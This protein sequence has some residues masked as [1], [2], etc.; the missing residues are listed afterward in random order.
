MD[1]NQARI[2][3]PPSWTRFVP[4]KLKR[5]LM[6]PKGRQVLIYVQLYA[7]NRDRSANKAYKEKY[8]LPKCRKRNESQATTTEYCCESDPNH[9][10]WH[11]LPSL[12]PFFFWYRRATSI[13]FVYT[14]IKYTSSCLTESLV[15]LMNLGKPAHCYAL[16][17][18]LV[19]DRPNEPCGA[20][21]ACFHLM[22][23]LLSL[24]HQPMTVTTFNFLMLDD[25]DILLYY[26]LIGTPMR[27]V[28]FKDRL[29]ELRNAMSHHDY[30]RF[31]MTHDIIGVTIDYGSAKVPKVRPN[32]T[33]RACEDLRNF[34]ISL[35]SFGAVLLALA[36]YFVATQL[37]ILHANDQ[38][39]LKR[40]PN[41]DPHLEQLQRTGLVSE[42]RW[43]FHLTVNVLVAIIFD[44]AE[45]L[46]L[47]F[48]SG[49]SLF[50]SVLVTLVLNRDLIVYWNH[51]DSKI[52][53]LLQFSREKRMGSR[54]SQVQANVDVD[55][56]VLS[57][58]YDQSIY[59]LL[60]EI[61]DFIKHLRRANEV[62]GDMITTVI[63]VW[64]T[65]FVF[66]I[67]NI[68]SL[69]QKIPAGVNVMLMFIFF[70]TSVLCVLAT[71]VHRN[72]LKSYGNIC[73]LM[74]L[75]ESCHK[76][77]F[78]EILD[79]FVRRRTCYTIYR[80]YVMTTTSYL[81]IVGYSVSCFFVLGSMYRR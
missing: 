53:L 25:H 46:F 38:S 39:Y 43:S 52:G 21:F 8:K 64:F 24:A 50:T 78:V 35:S 3:E 60:Q 18:F 17:R 20:F 44:V 69:H 75:D 1:S 70:V 36:T 63:N 41:C 65:I 57:S 47:W 4:D 54:G 76:K 31:L 73:S 29:G 74:C 15:G 79:Y 2:G 30:S 9:W 16:G 67:Y 34:M 59:E 13:Y 58:S 42:D 27:S 51:L 71:T 10:R 26:K 49:L 55:G 77:R 19:Y 62:V 40:Y 72:C 33:K 28:V 56:I 6:S 11:E 48:T 5:F 68:T 66:I 7:F 22:G 45:N 61:C 23:R 14:I 37:L 12:H 80:T 32:R 81:T